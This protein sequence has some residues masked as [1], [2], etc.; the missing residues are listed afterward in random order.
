MCADDFPSSNYNVDLSAALPIKNQWV[1]IWVKR[2]WEHKNSSIKDYDDNGTS[3]TINPFCMTT[4]LWLPGRFSQWFSI[5]VC[6]AKLVHPQMAALHNS[7]RLPIIYTKPMLQSSVD[8][9]RVANVGYGKVTVK[10]ALTLRTGNE[11]LFR[12]RVTWMYQNLPYSLTSVLPRLAK[13]ATHEPHRFSK[14][15][16]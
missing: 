15:A 3:P 6:T 16:C 14:Y 9:F 8:P 10:N 5:E 2:W 7:Y 1:C 13:R 4:L 12:M 11:Y